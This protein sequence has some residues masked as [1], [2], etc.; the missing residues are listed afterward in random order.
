M[1]IDI[2]PEI[3]VFYILALSLFVGKIFEEI[4][5]R[6]RYPP[7]LGDILAGLILGQSILGIFIVTDTVK[8][9]AWFGVALLLFYAG[10]E[11]SFRDF[12]RLLKIAGL[13]T[14]GEVASAF[15]IG[16]LVG[17]LMGYPF[18]RSFFLGTIL[19]A[20]SVSL[21]VRT[22]M[23]MGKL[24]TVEG[25]MIVEIAVLDDIAS[26]IVIAIGTSLIQ[27][28]GVDVISIGSAFV[29]ALGVWLIIV[30]AL[31]WFAPRLPRIISKLS[32]ED[33]TISLLIAIFSGI[34][35][36]VHFAGVSPLIGAYAAG[37]A[38]SDVMATKEIKATVRR[39][40]V[41]F[42]TVYF[43]A[44]VAELDLKTVIKPELI[45]F[46]T[47]MTLAAF[48]GKMLGAGLTSFILGFPLRSS[49]RIS[50]GLFPRCEFAIIAAYIAVSSGI[51]GAEAYLA[52]LIVVIVT[53]L[54][55]PPFLK[56]VFSGKEY[57]E[58]KLRFPKTI[59][60]AHK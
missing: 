31:H 8:A 34:A 21:T 50:V 41:L 10:L 17:Y 9:I 60:R 19:V 6:L 13:L 52:A 46:Y 54:I 59:I 1:A 5:I 48:I 4:I 18:M 22:L 30:F 23:E 36:L 40:A 32:V 55:T 37:L 58:I 26:L 47:L 14:V 49:L 12:I 20:T 44:T 39:L 27:A 2:P 33:A 45:G 38:L 25:Q 3:I 43:I 7:V 28:G 57:N 35:V 53:N 24:G 16:Y 56:W 29:K 11:A 42:S 51:L 15:S